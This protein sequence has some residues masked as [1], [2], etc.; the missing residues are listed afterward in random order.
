MAST[1]SPPGPTPDR[2]SPIA[3]SYAIFVTPESLQIWQYRH[4]MADPEGTWG[5]V[6]RFDQ[7]DAPQFSLTHATLTVPDDDGYWVYAKDYDC[8]LGC[9]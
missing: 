4:S 9:D 2:G 1:N 5:F 3:D 8:I 7:H 6:E